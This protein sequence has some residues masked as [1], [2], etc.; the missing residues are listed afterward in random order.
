[1]TAPTARQLFAFGPDHDG[2]ARPRR[3]PYH[4][5]LDGLRAVAVLAVL[6][7]HQ[8]PARLPGGFLGVDVFFVLS[9]YLITSLL[10]AEHEREG[11]IALRSFW[12]RRLRRLL[13][14]LLLCLLLVSAYALWL[15]PPDT[16]AQLRGDGLASLA[17]VLNWRFVLEGRSYFFEFFPSPLRHLWSL[18]VEEQWYLIWPFVVAVTLRGPGARG[19][20][21]AQRVLLVSMAAAAASAVWMSWLFDGAQDPS[22]A[23]YGT[24][25]HASPLLLGAALAALAAQHRVRPGRTTP[26]WPVGLGGL[27]GA[28]VLAWAM[29]SMTGSSAWLYQGG[30]AVVAVA[31]AAIIAAV[32]HESGPWWQDPLRPLL[33]LAPL[34]WLGRISYGVYLY[35]WPLYFVLTPE[36]TGLTGPALFAVRVG[37]TIAVATL[38]WWAIEQPIRRGALARLRVSTLLLP[39]AV[40]IVVVALLATTAGATAPW[41]TRDD[42]EV[43]DRPAPSVPPTSPGAPASA[44]PTRVLFVGDSVAYTL[45]IGFEGAV[46]EEAELLTWNQAVLY[47]ELLPLPRREGGEGGEVKAP[48][49]R[50]ADWQ[51]LWGAA[52]TEYDPDVAVA[53]VGAW[54]VFDRR[55]GDAWVPFGSERHD[56]LL[57]RQLRE[58][59][60]TLGAAGATVVLVTVPPNERTDGVSTVEWTAAERWRTEHINE[61]LGEVADEATADGADVVLLDLGGEVCPTPATGCP[62][63]IDGVRVRGDGIHY[64][65]EGARLVAR[66]LAPRL[67]E[68]GLASRAAR[69]GSSAASGPG[70]PTTTAPAASTTTPPAPTST[71]A[72]APT[73]TT[74]DPAATEP[75]TPTAA[76][77]AQSPSGAP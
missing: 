9:G 51:G 52:V 61:L 50:C 76:S 11:G 35:H 31:T 24:D 7:Y 49:D 60:D 71:T 58:L 16:L 18:S 5:A 20:R 38:S 48:S 64:T 8:N 1:M 17:Y 70:G 72:T 47:C 23:Y 53:L 19:R 40:L 74:P 42:L 2:D 15:A 34:R 28:G 12:V 63:E 22:R 67:R 21:G 39:G 26:A 75:T 65:E 32:V 37:A 4:P 62:L 66:W 56:E 44:S 25:A 27:V 33:A 57:R 36:R 77:T 13:P 3:V 46:D 29:R 59:V 14:A 54:E 45:A 69:D 43:S 55:E 6:A 30:F 10:L 73:P 41:L 68:L